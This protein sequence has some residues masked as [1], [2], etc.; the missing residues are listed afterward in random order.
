MMMRGSKVI[1]GDGHDLKKQSRRRRKNIMRM[2]EKKGKT[3]SIYGTFSGQS[4]PS[5]K[6][7]ETTGATT[8]CM[9]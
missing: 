5:E 7:D 8:K 3:T 6:V 1:E 2:I 4:S 9:V